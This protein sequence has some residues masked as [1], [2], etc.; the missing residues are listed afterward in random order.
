MRIPFSPNSLARAVWTWLGGAAGTTADR[1]VNTTYWNSAAVAVPNSPGEPLV[2]IN[3]IRGQIQTL[4]G[5]NRITVSI[6]KSLN[7]YN[8]SIS[9]APSFSGTKTAAITSVDTTRAIAIPAKT[10]GTSSGDVGYA[11]GD[12]VNLTYASVQFGSATT[13]Q[14]NGVNNADGGASHNLVYA[15]W[16]VE[17]Y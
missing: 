5:N 9:C 4:D 1:A 2:D 16:V 6:V 8:N 14:F 10:P 12:N 15:F 7:Y 11:I 13:F 3:R 17:F